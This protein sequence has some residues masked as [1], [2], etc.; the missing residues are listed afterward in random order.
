MSGFS[1]VFPP[2]YSPGLLVTIENPQA[3]DPQGWETSPVAWRPS[4]PTCTLWTAEGMPLRILGEVAECH[5]KMSA[6]FISHRGS[7]VCNLTSRLTLVG[8]LV[9]LGISLPTERGRPDRVPLEFQGNGTSNCSEQHLLSG[10][11]HTHL[12]RGVWFASL[13][14]PSPS[15]THP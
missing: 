9:D 5:L 2:F 12:N 11:T 13:L 15:Q 6:A 7:P 14:T 3:L 1:S 8:S 4:S 10:E